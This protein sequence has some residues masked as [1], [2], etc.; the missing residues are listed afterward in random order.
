M[1]AF[2]NMRDIQRLV[3]FGTDVARAAA[4]E[5]GVNANEQAAKAMESVK[6][7]MSSV[8][9]EDEA[10]RRGVSEASESSERYELKEMTCPNCGATMEPNEYAV[11]NAALGTADCPYCGSQI[12]V[13]DRVRNAEVLHKANMEKRQTDIEARRTQIEHDRLKSEIEHQKSIDT[14]NTIDSVSRGIDKI[15]GAF[16]AVKI[17]CITVI[18][19]I[20]LVIVLVKVI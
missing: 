9:R 15:S 12:V 17:G 1:P 20:I 13:N 18:V 19:L 14:I 10:Y 7:E 3:R 2:R 6:Q 4:R 5:A 8:I 16:R 11:N